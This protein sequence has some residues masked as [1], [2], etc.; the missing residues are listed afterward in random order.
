MK[1]P[2]GMIR[3]NEE[4][5]ISCIMHIFLTF[6][7]N[8]SFFFSSFY[9]MSSIFIA[10]TTNVQ[11]AIKLMQE[12]KKL[13]YHAKGTYESSNF[14]IINKWKTFFQDSKIVKAA[15][16]VYIWFNIH[17]LR[18]SFNKRNAYVTTKGIHGSRIP[19]LLLLQFQSTKL[20]K[21]T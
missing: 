9:Y 2:L 20:L 17:G 1:I 4:S 3:Q 16:N 5:S 6:N 18:R 19:F 15:W 21:S 12:N 11:R 7:P 8:E 10:D 14:R 13:D